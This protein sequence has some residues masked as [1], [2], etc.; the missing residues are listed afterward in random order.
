MPRQIIRS[1]HLW[2]ALGLWIAFWPVALNIER[3]LLFEIMNALSVAIGFGV[4][5]G[6][7]PGVIEA[8]RAGRRLTDGHLLVLGVAVVW[9]SIVV[10]Q[11][12]QW[13]WRLSG[14]PESWEE[15]LVLAF[16]IWMTLTAGLLHMCATEVIDGSMPRR[17]WVR[18]GAIIAAGIA[19]AMIAYVFIEPLATLHFRN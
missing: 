8:L 14:K 4:M 2:I 10:R 12:H 13:M 19:M 7:A 1:V 16:A 6:F 15:S 3:L 5:V 11:F 17:G 9:G 18:V